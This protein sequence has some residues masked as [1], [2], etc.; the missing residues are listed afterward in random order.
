MVHW[1]KD[2]G[3]AVCV[4]V[5]A[6]A[7]A[8][9]AARPALARPAGQRR[10]GGREPASANSWR[11]R[12]PAVELATHLTPLTH[13]PP[14]DDSPGP[15]I[16]LLGPDIRPGQVGVEQVVG[17][18]RFSW[19]DLTLGPRKAAGLTP[20]CTIPRPEPALLPRA[21]WPKVSGEVFSRAQPSPQTHL[22]P[23]LTYRPL[24]MPHHDKR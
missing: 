21:F 24:P 11:P 9:G 13:S 23:F 20:L 18:G 3:A 17:G 19:R 6:G 2:F 15:N 4:L 7:G 22:T 14:S 8:A 16:A 12:G 5:H 1:C 10:A